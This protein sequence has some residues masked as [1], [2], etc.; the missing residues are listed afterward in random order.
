MLNIC[1]LRESIWLHRVHIAV[2]HVGKPR[3][4][5]YLRQPSKK[6][7]QR[8]YSDSEASS[9]QQQAQ[10]GEG[11]KRRRQ[12]ITM[13]VD[14]MSPECHRQ[15]DQMK[16]P[17]D[18]YRWGTIYLSI[19]L[20]HSLGDRWGTTRLGN[21]HSPFLLFLCSPHGVAQF[22][23]SPIS[24]V[25]FPS[26]SLSASPSPTPYSVPWRTVL[27]SPEVLVTWSYHFILRRSSS[28][29]V[30]KKIFNVYVLPVM[31]CGSETWVL[32]KAMEEMMA[33]VQ[34]KMERIMLGFSLKKQ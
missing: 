9:G 1:R 7:L 11:C 29:K 17:W 34:H 2:H 3:S 20:S 12:N 16:E 25:I 31:T 8:C 19:Y 5:S 22:Q 14:S 4:W 27:A 28:M 33:V 10:G 13:V 6:Y 26:F 32:H 21:Q 18:Q 30:K 24:D 15:Q 23:T